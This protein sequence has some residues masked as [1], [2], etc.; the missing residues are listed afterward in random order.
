[1][2]QN[3]IID[4]MRVGTRQVSDKE[5]IQE[6]NSEDEPEKLSNRSIKNEK[7]VKTIKQPITYTTGGE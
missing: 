6:T 7:Q 5:Y 1:M 3:R 4:V 2:H